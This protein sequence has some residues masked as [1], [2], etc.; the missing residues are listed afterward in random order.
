MCELTK[1]VRAVS[2]VS[3]FIF[4]IIGGITWGVYGLIVNVLALPVVLGVQFVIYRKCV[5][6][7]RPSV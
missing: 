4:L 2:T 6:F 3:G 5:A 1:L 7:F